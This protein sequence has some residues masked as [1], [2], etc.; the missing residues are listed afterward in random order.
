LVL[1]LFYLS[2]PTMNILLENAEEFVR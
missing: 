1:N 2:N